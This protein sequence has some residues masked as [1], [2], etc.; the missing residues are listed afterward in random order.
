MKSLRKILLI[1]LALALFIAPLSA[2]SL[3]ASHP[4]ED[5]Y[6]SINQGIRYTVNFNFNNGDKA[7]SVKVGS[8][9][10][11][12][13][14]TNPTKEN[15]V[16]IG[17]YLDEALTKEYDFSLGVTKDIK[18]YAKY[19]LDYASL[20]NRITLEIMK[21]TVTVIV[22]SYGVGVRNN[23]TGSGIIIKEDYNFYYALTNNHVA[24]IAE[25]C[26]VVSYN[27]EDYKGQL[28][29]AK[30]VYRDSDYDLAIIRFIKGTNALGVI[31]M[32]DKDISVGEEIASLGQPEQQNNAITYGKVTGYVEA[33][34]FYTTEKDEFGNDITV[35][36]DESISNVR[37]D[38]IEHTSYINSGS[39]GGALIDENLK[40]VGINYS[41]SGGNNSYAIPIS[42]VKEFISFY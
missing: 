23:K 18:L 25:G 1:I 4:N 27:V 40:L 9:K 11:V 20:T 42:R 5:L 6:D 34:R 39:S 21:S 32:A 38:V 3:G 22:D 37:F 19:L 31:E 12:N 17:W 29:D 33:P 10:K 7:Q 13:K 8:G 15:S 26:S 36:I 16:F 28:Y 35:E 24:I 2:C 14:P 41:G 30:C